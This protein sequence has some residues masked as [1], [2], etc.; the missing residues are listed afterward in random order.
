MKPT[1][2]V[3]KYR[4]KL[5]T[6]TKPHLSQ[7]ETAKWIEGLARFGYAAKGIVY[8]LIGILAFQAAW[9][10]RGEARGSEGVFRTIANQPFGSAL[11]FVVAVGL[12]GYVTWR[13]VQ[14]IYDPEHNDSGFNA[15]ARR[16]AYLTSGLI[17]GALSAAAFKIVFSSSS[18]AS[19]GESSGEQ[20]A[21]LMAH[22]FGHWLI[23]AVGLASAAYG[24][25]CIYRGIKVKF[26]KKLKTYAM[27]SAEKRWAVRVGRLGLL[28]RGIV[29][30]AVGYFFSR[31]ALLA[32]SS[33]AKTTGEALKAIQQQPYGGVVMG[34]IAL[35]LIAYGIH[36]LVQ[37]R[38]RRISPEQ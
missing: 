19:S 25:S 33:Q 37:A 13:F 24:M 6:R 21:T 26:R 7:P 10:W 28:A 38:Y 30:I 2:I 12:L 23:G 3:G 8:G 18:S 31:A 9:T 36:M 32:D 17:Y 16:L 27:S 20:A 15:I 34:A 29:S 1:G 11:L 4:V 5:E 14:A 35:G 22:P